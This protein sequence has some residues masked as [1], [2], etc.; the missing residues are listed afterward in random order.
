[1]KTYIF[2]N[3]EFYLKSDV[4]I[5]L[6]TIELTGWKGKDNIEI[7]NN[8]LENVWY[9]KE[10]RKDKDTSDVAINVHT[11]KQEDVDF[12]R[13]LIIERTKGCRKTRYRELVLDIITKKN[14]PI[15]L[16]EFNGGHNRSKYYFKYYYYPLKVLEFT[17][18]IKYGG[19]GT[20][21]RLI[22]NQ[23]QESIVDIFEKYGA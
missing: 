7:T 4:D 21:I 9:V 23:V 3:R 15:I 12:I 19:R 2:D 22:D 17:K 18:E 20:V 1:M 14:L 8:K 11:V 5:E 16:D 6:K 10:H 13:N